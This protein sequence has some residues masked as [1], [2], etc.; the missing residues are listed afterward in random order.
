MRTPREAT[1]LD[2]HKNCVGDLEVKDN[3]FAFSSIT[4]FAEELA[5]SEWSGSTADKDRLWV[6]PSSGLKSLS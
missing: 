3:L 5:H 2:G 1:V 6:V 4:I